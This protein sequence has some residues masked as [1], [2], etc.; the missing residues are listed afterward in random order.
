MHKNKLTSAKLTQ[1]PLYPILNNSLLGTLAIVIV[2]LTTQVSGCFVCTIDQVGFF[3]IIFSLALV[4]CVSCHHK[5]ANSPFSVD[6]IF[7][8]FFLLQAHFVFLHLG[9]EPK[10][11]HGMSTSEYSQFLFA[12]GGRRATI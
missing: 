8:L 11:L 5:V 12:T 3:L 10:Q 1:S 7:L 9:V 4:M 6:I 2:W